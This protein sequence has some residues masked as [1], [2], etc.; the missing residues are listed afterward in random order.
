MAKDRVTLRELTQILA[1]F[2]VEV[3]PKRGKGS[4]KLFAKQFPEGRFTY[5]I[6]DQKDVLPC[7]VIGARRKFRLRVED[8][9]TDEEFFGR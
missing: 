7:Y 9:V 2:D 3:A 6:P 5:P 8:G 4:H 1:R